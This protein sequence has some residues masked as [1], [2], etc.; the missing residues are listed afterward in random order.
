[1][2]KQ[3]N[4]SKISFKELYK[5]QKQLSYFKKHK[6]SSE[7]DKKAPSFNDYQRHELYINNFLSY[8]DFD[9]CSSLLDFACGSALLSKKA[10]VFVDDIVL[11]DFSPK[12][13]EFAKLNCPKAQ[14]HQLDFSKINTLPKCD[15]VFASRCLMVDDLYESLKDLLDKTNMRFY[16]TI[17][18]DGIFLSKKIVEVLD[19]DITP[20]PNYIY[21]ANILYEL[22]YDFS[23]NTIWAKNPMYDTFDE[24]KDSVESIYQTLSENEISKLKKLYFEEGVKNTTDYSWVLFCVDKTKQD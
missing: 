1:M 9:G 18:K 5:E 4:L 21:A 13:L 8:V 19:E 23:L 17:K 15:L 12:M 6:D 14:I 16:F 3:N 2:L 10:S 20:F 11:A 7:W 24:F 22:G